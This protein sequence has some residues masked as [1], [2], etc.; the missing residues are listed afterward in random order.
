MSDIE[1]STEEV[2]GELQAR[3]DDS[4][5]LDVSGKTV[6]GLQSMIADYDYVV[7]LRGY[8]RDEEDDPVMSNAEK[9]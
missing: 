1:D 3:F 4:V 8:K 5:V 9:T 6:A 7:L 2:K